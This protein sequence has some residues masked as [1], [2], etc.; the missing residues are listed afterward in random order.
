MLEP[1]DG[2]ARRFSPS[3]SVSALELGKLQPPEEGSGSYPC[4]AGRLL[5]VAL[6][7][8]RGDGILLFASESVYRLRAAP[9]V[10]QPCFLSEPLVKI[11]DDLPDSGPQLIETVAQCPFCDTYV[12]R[13]EIIR[14]DAPLVSLRWDCLRRPCSHRSPG[15]RAAHLH[16][17]RCEG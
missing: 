4:G 5:D 15:I 1:R 16:W 13:K 8:Q 9:G 7:Q 14:R 10:V 3:L 6:G 2:L 11:L 12:C 17:H